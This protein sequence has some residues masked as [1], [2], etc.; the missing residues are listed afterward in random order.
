[1]IWFPLLL[2]T[3][4]INGWVFVCNLNLICICSKDEQLQL[5]VTG[6]ILT[7]PLN[8]IK[9]NICHCWMATSTNPVITTLLNVCH[10]KSYHTYS[11]CYLRLRIL[12]SGQL[13]LWRDWSLDCLVWWLLAHFKVKEANLS[14][15]GIQCH[16]ILSIIIHQLSCLFNLVSYV[17]SCGESH[18]HSHT[19]LAHYMI[20]MTRWSPSSSSSS[21]SLLCKTWRCYLQ[22]GEHHDQIW[23]IRN[24]NAGWLVEQGRK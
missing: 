3:P 10:M 23:T 9:V 12:A 14:L 11:H 8:C 15:K 6:R 18:S 17:S 20:L 16:H 2:N 5:R 13:W 1:M 7:S 21:S 19:R 24:R 22:T 4:A